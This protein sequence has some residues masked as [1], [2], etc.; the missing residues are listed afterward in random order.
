MLSIQLLDVLIF[1]CI[2]SVLHAYSRVVGRANIFTMIISSAAFS[3]CCPCSLVYIFL[4]YDL[5]FSRVQSMHMPHH[6]THFDEN[7][8][9]WCEIPEKVD[10]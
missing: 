3:L 10:E 8:H 5:D 7:S 2:S 9:S 6:T 1:F 4:R